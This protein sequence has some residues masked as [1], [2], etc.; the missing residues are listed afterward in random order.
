MSQLPKIILLWLL[1]A[2]GTMSSQMPPSP[3]RLHIT[4]NPPNPPKLNITIDG[5]T[6]W[7]TP[8]TLVVSPGKD[9][10]V[11]ITGGPV[12]CQMKCTPSSG[13][14]VEAAC[15]QPATNSSSRTCQPVQ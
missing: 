9:Y 6:G 4:T 10:K 5:R 11:S 15:P 2:A 13:Q 14:T 12:D 3:A 1:V 7:Q 8:V